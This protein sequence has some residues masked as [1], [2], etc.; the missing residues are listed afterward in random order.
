MNHRMDD[1]KFENSIESSFSS[2]QVNLLKNGPLSVLS[3][4]NVCPMCRGIGLLSYQNLTL[5]INR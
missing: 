2:F 3:S 1:N 5:K 4:S